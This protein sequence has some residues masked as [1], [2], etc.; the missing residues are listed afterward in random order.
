MVVEFKR[1]LEC[2]ISNFDIILENKNESRFFLICGI[3][4]DN[5]KRNKCLRFKKRNH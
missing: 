1:L 5:K 2:I 4:S 3:E